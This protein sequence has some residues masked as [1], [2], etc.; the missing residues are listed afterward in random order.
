[1]GFETHYHSYLTGAGNGHNNTEARTPPP[2]VPARPAPSQSASGICYS[3]LRSCDRVEQHFPDHLRS[4]LDDEQLA[5][6]DE[7]IETTRQDRQAAGQ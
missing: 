3:P 5:G 1:M 7:V 2:T 6:S 4:R